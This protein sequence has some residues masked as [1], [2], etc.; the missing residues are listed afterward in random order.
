VWSSPANEHEAS[1]DHVALAAN[2]LLTCAFM[3]SPLDPICQEQNQGVVA[4][5][6]GFILDG[7]L[8]E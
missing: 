8:D 3:Q 7:N 4:V 6:V 1:A 2:K 5:V